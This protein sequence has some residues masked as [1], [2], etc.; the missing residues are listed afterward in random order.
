MTGDTRSR[1]VPP[2]PLL[3]QPQLPVPVPTE[4]SLAD[5]TA[6]IRHSHKEAMDGLAHGAEYGIRTGLAL[7]AAK[8]R[9]KK[10]HGHGYW[11]DYV[12]LECG[13][14]MRVAQNYMKMARRKDVLAP[15][16]AENAKCNSPL[17]QG[18]VLK[19]LSIAQKKRARPKKASPT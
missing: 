12:A 11:Q 17:S 9:L 4:R 18:A 8:E 1:T 10:E 5:L 19:F 6:I 3:A 7:I 14:S 16:L 2:I 13:L 15:L